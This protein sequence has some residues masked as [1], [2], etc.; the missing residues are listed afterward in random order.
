[1]RLR[2]QKLYQALSSLNILVKLT[3]ENK[4]LLFKSKRTIQR[5]HS[6]DS[7]NKNQHNEDF[8]M[9]DYQ[10]QKR[11]QTDNNTP[12]KPIPKSAQQQ[13]VNSKKLG[14]N[15]YMLQS[16][17]D[18]TSEYCTFLKF[19]YRSYGELAEA[20][21]VIEPICKGLMKVSGITFNVENSKITEG[22][23][24]HKTVFYQEV[25]NDQIVA[26]NFGKYNSQKILEGSLRGAA[27]L[28][29]I[30]EQIEPMLKI[31]EDINKNLIPVDIGSL[32]FDAEAYFLFES[33]NLQKAMHEFSGR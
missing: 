25:W 23:S 6:A 8:E 18:C 28:P 24:V 30:K 19:L 11:A 13:S 2:K 33:T 1:M 31:E 20:I 26:V 32:C 7:L 15:N 4:H 29:L 22:G 9:N 3:E 16:V 12:Q 14:N 21:K 27:Q 17:Y 10:K 5:R